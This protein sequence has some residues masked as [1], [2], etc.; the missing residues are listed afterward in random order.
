[1]LPHRNV[2]PIEDKESYRWL[3]SLKNSRPVRG[4]T[5]LVTVCDREADIYE[6]FQ[7]SAELA[8]PVLVR[9]NYD[10]PINKRSMYA[11]K[12]HIEACVRSILVQEPPPGDFEIIVTDGMSDDGTRDILIQLAAENPRLRI[13]DNLGSIVSTGLNTAIRTAQGKLIIRMDVHTEYAPD[14]VHQCL[15]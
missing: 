5:Q 8:A 2:L 4:N 1:M 9:A 7:L 6:L 3:E 11:E 12:D 13:I 14:Y 10:R 15:A